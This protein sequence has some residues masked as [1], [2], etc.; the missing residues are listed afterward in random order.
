V[1][2]T[3]Q[4]RSPATVLILVALLVGLGLWYGFSRATPQTD[5]LIGQQRHLINPGFQTVT[6]FSTNDDLDNGIRALSVGDNAHATDL[7]RR[8]SEVPTGSSVLVLSTAA[9]SSHPSAQVRVLTGSAAARTGW[10]TVDKLAP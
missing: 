5:P 4:Y 3:T 2:Q 1:T 9:A 6:L 7:A 10:V 8:G